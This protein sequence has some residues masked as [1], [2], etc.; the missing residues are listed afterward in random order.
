MKYTMEQMVEEVSK[1]FEEAPE[2]Q[3]REFLK[4]SAIEYHHTLGREI[5]NRFG[6]WFNKWEPKIIDGVDYS[7]DHP[8]NIS[9]RVIES[10]QDKYRSINEQN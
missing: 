7:E 5:R 8:D 1:W 2:D 10:I 4:R 9:G 6:L 3:Q